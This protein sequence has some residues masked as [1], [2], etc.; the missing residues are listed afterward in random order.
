MV[1]DDERAVRESLRRALELE[2]YEIE[3]AENGNDALDLLAKG[4]QPDAHSF[5][6]FARDGV[7][8]DSHAHPVPQPVLD[9][10]TDL[11]SRVSPPGVL[12]ERDENF[13]EPAELEGELEAIRVAVEKGRAHGTEAAVPPAAKVAVPAPATDSAR[14][15][16]QDDG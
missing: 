3:L 7:W 11:A 5:D 1:V 4:A 2:G 15:R 13:P 10:L 16:Q 14:Q 9:I 6:G 8:H 12:L